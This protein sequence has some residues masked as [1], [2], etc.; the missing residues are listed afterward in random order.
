MRLL[1]CNQYFAN[2]DQ[3]ALGRSKQDIRN[4]AD[5][6]TAFHK[7]ERLYKDEMPTL[8]GNALMAILE[9][10][11]ARIVEHPKCVMLTMTSE[12]TR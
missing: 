6:V 7:L 8:T 10:M 3:P 9:Q 5:Q 4:L 12:S 2:L 11:Q 1:L